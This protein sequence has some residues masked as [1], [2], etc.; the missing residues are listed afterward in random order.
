MHATV[1]CWAVTG[2]LPIHRT[3]AQGAA[4]WKI[5]KSGTEF[6]DVLM[7]CGRAGK[8]E[9]RAE[10]IWEQAKSVLAEEDLQSASTA[11]ESPSD[12]NSR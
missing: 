5:K 6:V 4:S 9:G 8:P 3:S 10:E 11:S 12:P 1:N 2:H 7:S